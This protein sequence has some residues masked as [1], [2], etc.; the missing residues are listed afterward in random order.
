MMTALTRC[1]WVLPI[2]SK[3]ALNANVTTIDVMPSNRHRRYPSAASR[4]PCT[5]RKP[6]TIGR[7][8]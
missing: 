8:T 2:P 3:N 4:T 6:S 5:L 1:T 7:T